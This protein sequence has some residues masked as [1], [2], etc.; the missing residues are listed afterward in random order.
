MHLFIRN[1][2]DPGRYITRKSHLSTAD[3]LAWQLKE[4]LNI[5][6]PILKNLLPMVQVDRKHC[7]GEIE[8]TLDVRVIKNSDYLRI[9]KLLA[10]DPVQESIL[11]MELAKLEK[12][13]IEDIKIVKDTLGI[14]EG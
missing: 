13:Y 9:K 2:C 1:L 7:K 11:E 12:Q 5:I 6:S 8:T 10:L 14:K 3:F 4:K